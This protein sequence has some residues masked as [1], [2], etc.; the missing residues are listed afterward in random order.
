[1]TFSRQGA[2][3]IRTRLFDAL[4][5]A[6]YRVNVSTYHSLAMRIVESNATALGWSAPPSV[7]AGSEQE[8][9]IFDLLADEEPERWHVAYR[10]ILH[11][12]VMAAEVT[13]FFLRC[14]EHLLNPE[15][16]AGHAREQWRGIP[17]FFDRYLRAQV[18]AGRTD[19][20]RIVGDG[21]G[22]VQARHG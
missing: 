5:A 21:C 19:Y 6:S 16:V 14:H 8:R 15:D 1:M 13:D 20:G 4:G 12:D 3:D 18:E 10:G 17:G 22:T 9:F 2:N 11:S 7:L